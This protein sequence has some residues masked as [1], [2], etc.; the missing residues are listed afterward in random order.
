MKW[1]K[2]SIKLNSQNLALTILDW[3]AWLLHDYW[4]LI[5]WPLLGQFW[6]HNLQIFHGD[7]SKWYL[8][9]NDNVDGD[10]DDEDDN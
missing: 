2:W 4:D 6:S 5:K 8:L 9:D 7:K 1:I 3:K 10:D